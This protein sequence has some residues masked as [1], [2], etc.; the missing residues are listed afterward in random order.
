MAT[1]VGGAA[2]IFFTAPGSGSGIG[3]VHPYPIARGT[4]YPYAVFGSD[5]L[6]LP[7]VP[8]EPDVTDYPVYVAAGTA[9]TGR[10]PLGVVPRGEL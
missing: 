6:D 4:Y 7:H 5:A 3:H 10:V 8:V 2:A 9:S 1:A